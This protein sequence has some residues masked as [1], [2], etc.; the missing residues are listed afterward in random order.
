MTPELQ[1]HVSHKWIVPG[2]N[3]DY[4]Y[5]IDLTLQDVVDGP[6]PSQSFARY[7]Y[8]IKVK[9]QYSEGPV[10]AFSIS[11]ALNLRYCPPAAASVLAYAMDWL[12]RIDRDVPSDMHAE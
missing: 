4:E 5:S 8:D 9:H 10:V 2:D 6:E 12:E 11:M 7:K 1:E 3:G